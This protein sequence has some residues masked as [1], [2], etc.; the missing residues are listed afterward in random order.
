MQKPLH[1]RC[2]Q[3]SKPVSSLVWEP[4]ASKE[5]GTTSAPNQKRYQSTEVIHRS[6]G[7][8]SNMVTKD[9]SRDTNIPEKC[10]NRTYE[11]GKGILEVYASNR[12]PKA[13]WGCLAI[14]HHCPL[15]EF[16]QNRFAIIRIGS[17]LSLNVL[18]MIQA[19]FRLLRIGSCASQPPW[20]PH[21]FCIRAA[22][23]TCM[24]V[25]Q[26]MQDK[27]KTRIAKA[28]LLPRPRKR[29]KAPRLKMHDRSTALMEPHCSGVRSPEGSKGG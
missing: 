7:F 22:T 9:L 23:M 4:N 18:S 26:S 16:T 27:Q 5:P 28:S 13:F 24:D 2:S 10:C 15:Q 25:L 20:F 12:V 1:Q 11:R 8:A 29:P 6:F 19:E 21:H 3:F 14:L 17:N